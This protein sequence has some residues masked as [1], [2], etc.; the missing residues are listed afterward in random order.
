MGSGYF[1]QGGF[2]L[3]LQN[4][5]HISTSEENLEYKCMPLH[6]TNTF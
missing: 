2:K 4:D 1:V 6:P 5:S 3:Q